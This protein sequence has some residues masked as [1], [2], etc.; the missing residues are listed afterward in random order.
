MENQYGIVGNSLDKSPS[1][2]AAIRIPFNCFCNLFN[3]P[4]SFLSSSF[5]AAKYVHSTLPVKSISIGGCT[6]DLLR[7][8]SD[9]ARKI[10]VV[11]SFCVSVT[12]SIYRG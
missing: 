10:R 2:F 9:Y 12:A 5:N 7:K 4:S 6:P 3:C 8:R 1:A 11:L